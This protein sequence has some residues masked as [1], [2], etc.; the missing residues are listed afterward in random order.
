CRVSR[1]LSG[2]KEI[3][4]AAAPPARCNAA[5]NLEAGPSRLRRPAVT[6]RVALSPKVAGW[7]VASTP[8]V[9]PIRPRKD[10][11]LE[12]EMPASETDAFASW[13]LSFGPEAR[14]SSPKAVR[15][16]IVSQLEAVAADG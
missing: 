6:A 10:R 7:A 2:F 14:L 11:W 8:G 13:V 4:P 3:G 12:V 5:A 1:L 15:D 16:Q 9:R